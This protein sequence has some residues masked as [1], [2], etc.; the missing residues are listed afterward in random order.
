MNYIDEDFSGLPWN[1]LKGKKVRTLW[2]AFSEYR[3]FAKEI[4]GV[5]EDL[6]FNYMALVY[7]KNSPLV[8]D[9]ESAKDR[10]YKALDELKVGRKDGKYDEALQDIV[11]GKNKDANRMIHRFLS[12]LND[13][14]FSLLQVTMISFDK[15]MIKLLEVSDDGVERAVLETNKASLQLDQ[16]AKRIQALKLEFYQRDTTILDEQDEEMLSY[17]RVPGYTERIVAG[18]IRI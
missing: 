14:Q 7:H 10:K 15:L 18:K 8:R 17:S 2:P 16:M 12:L 6:F 4:P 3:E 11:D 5:N 1:P 13:Q 9:Y